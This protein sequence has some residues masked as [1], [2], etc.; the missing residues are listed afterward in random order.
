MISDILT[1]CQHSNTF[2]KINARIGRMHGPAG[3]EMDV[4]LVLCNTAR[5]YLLDGRLIQIQQILQM[6]EARF[7]I[8]H[9]GSGSILA[10]LNTM[11]FRS[12]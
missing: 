9:Y 5:L 4:L 6:P 7:R 2:L 12:V 11:Y 10:L 8:R 3:S 1:A